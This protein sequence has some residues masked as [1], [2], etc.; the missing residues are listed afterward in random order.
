M[1]RFREAIQG[2]EVG[3]LVNNAAV[4]KPGALFLHEADVESLV[5]IIR[6]NVLALTQVTAA[7]LPVMVRQGRGTIVNI[8]SGSAVALPSF[9]L[10]SV[11]AATKRYKFTKRSSWACKLVSS[12]TALVSTFSC[13]ARFQSVFCSF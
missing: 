9:P 4:V 5:R 8:S 13:V 2:L 11:Y 3:V 7:V 1:A 12:Y 6:V 10:Y